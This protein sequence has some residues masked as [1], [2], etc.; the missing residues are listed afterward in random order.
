[1]WNHTFR[2][3][4]ISWGQWNSRPCWRL[5]IHLVMLPHV[6][7]MSLYYSN[8]EVPG[9]LGLLQLPSLTS[10]FVERPLH[11]PR[12]YSILPSTSFDGHLPTLAELAE[13]GLYMPSTSYSH[14]PGSPSNVGLSRRNTEIPPTATIA[15]EACEW[16]TCC[17]TSGH[18]SIW[19]S[20][21][22]IVTHYGI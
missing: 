13:V 21:V 8:G 7:W 19:N 1:M 18:S 20:A 12:P 22:T 9:I 11:F 14:L 4:Q 3:P 17:R 2:P 15:R 10:L 5:K 6:Q 16:S